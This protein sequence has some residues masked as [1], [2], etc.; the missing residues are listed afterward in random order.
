MVDRRKDYKI[1]RLFVSRCENAT[2][3]NDEYKVELSNEVN[4]ECVS[5]Y[6]KNIC[7]DNRY[8][9]YEVSRFFTVPDYASFLDSG[10]SQKYYNLDIILAVG[11]RFDFKAATIFRKW[12]SEEAKYTQVDPSFHKIYYFYLMQ[13]AFSFGVPYIAMILILFMTDQDVV[14]PII[15]LS[16]V[17]LVGVTTNAL[18]AMKYNEEKGYKRVYSNNKKK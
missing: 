10:K 1:I 18:N 6:L 3:K 17:L 16:S 11:Y 9:R 5:Q 4:A 8:L 7:E 12:V 2:S 15:T 13:T 14:I